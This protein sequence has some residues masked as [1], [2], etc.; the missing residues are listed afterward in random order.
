MSEKKIIKIL[1]AILVTII[2]FIVPSISDLFNSNLEKTFYSIG[3]ESKPDSNII[4]INVT[5]NDIENLGNWPLK[6]SYYALLIDNLTKLEVRKIGIE[7][8]LSKNLTSQNIYNNVFNESIRKS[9]K[10]VL[11][12]LAEDLTDNNETFYTTNILYPSPIIEVQDVL[13]GHINFVLENGILIPSK[14][15]T[16]SG[17]EFSFS[18]RLSDIMNDTSNIKVNFASSWQSF[19]NYSLLDFF[20]ML[21]N[22]DTRLVKFKDKI[23]LV[24]VS[25]PL[26]AKSINSYFNSE[27]PGLG[28]HAFALDN[29]LNNRMFNYQFISLSKYV[30]FIIIIFLA[31]SQ[32]RNFLLISLSI[33]IYILFF[34]LWLT[35]QLQLD[36]AA[37]LFPIAL[38]IAYNFFHSVTQRKKK[39]DATL[40]ETAILQRNLRVKEEK[41]EQL[42]TQLA[43]EESSSFDGLESKIREMQKEIDKLKSVEQDDKEQYT[44]R[45]EPKIFEGIVYRS[46][47]ME[48]IIEII[49]KV[50]PQNASVLVMGESGSGKELVANAIHN[51]SGR[52]KKNFVAV[53]CAALPDNLLESELF[54][55]VK[56]AFTGAVADK[57]GRFEEANNG[58]LFLD[59]IGETSENFQVKLLRVLQTGDFQKVGS[60]KTV[61]V[62]VRIVAATNNNLIEL[63]KFKKFREDLFYRLNVIIIELP[64]LRERKEDIELLAEYFAKG[65]E[66]DY[67]FSKAVMDRLI[68]NEWKGN[69]RELESTIK[70]SIIFAKSENRTLIKLKDLPDD[71]SKI[72]KDE[73]ENLIL[74]SLREKKFSH[75]SIN[76]TAKELGNLNRTVISEN[77]RGL[78]FRAYSQ[79]DFNIGLTVDEISSSDDI[80]IKEKVESK[81]NKFLSNI[82]NDVTKYSNKSFDEIKYLLNSKYKNLPQKYHVYLDLVIKKLMQTA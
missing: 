65:E 37:F 68:E 66:E 16:N 43:S 1:I 75:S 41:L 59:E 14:I 46:N 44:N 72:V 11:A 48:K 64:N 23:I 31:Y 57:I 60:S 21:E 27:L 50:A 25:D 69:I 34:V 62:D 79:N 36:Y 15:N 78:L 4:L 76:E 30:F 32:F 22:N 24:G 9:G 29:I 2:L 28:L 77:F 8:F 18:R 20:E 56:G 70:R 49:K 74:E 3:G 63:V 82:K 6:R 73:L 51:L 12:S 61:K 40:N 35:F 55:H 47:K 45:I 42:K 53:N 67:T 80:K 71:L 26:I 17:S 38:F 54:G 33:F 19:T 5:A 52:R 10:I 58:T 39:L 81:L 13:T 7:I